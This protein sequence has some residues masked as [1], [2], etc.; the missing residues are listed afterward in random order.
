MGTGIPWD[1]RFYFYI[2]KWSDMK[3]DSMSERTSTKLVGKRK[4]TIINVNMS[5]YLSSFKAQLKTYI[6]S[7]SAITPWLYTS[8]SRP[9]PIILSITSS[10]A[11]FC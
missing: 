1:V 9:F 11:P 5:H 8:S 3:L 7:L 6:L 2:S 4:S 10:F